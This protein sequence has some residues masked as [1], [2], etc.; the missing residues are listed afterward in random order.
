MRFEHKVV[1]DAP[2]QQVQDFL[3]DFNKSAYCVPGL[4]D[5]KD[6]GNDAYEGTIRVKIGPI[7]LNVG[8]KAQIDRQTDGWKVKGEGNDR[9]V[10]AAMHADVEAK[11]DEVT[12]NQTAVEIVADVQFAGRLAELGQPLIKKKA[13]S[14]V[15]EFA[16]NLRK[17][18]SS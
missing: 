18:I 12:A 14:F 10:G 11:L 4:K 7:G 16:Q 15:A 13:D 6:L 1:I 8:G 17:A 9:R 3:N 2:R 5:L